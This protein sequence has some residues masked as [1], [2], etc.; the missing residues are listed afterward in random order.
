MWT[1]VQTHYAALAAEENPV[2]VPRAG[3][4]LQ[5][6]WSS[7]I[8][9][10]TSFFMSLLLKV[11]SEEHDGWK[12]ENYIEE[13]LTRFETIRKAEEAETIRAYD[14]AKQQALLRKAD[15]P[16]KP[17]IK[18]TKFR[19][20]H[21]VSILKT[22][23][24]FMHAVMLEKIPQMEPNPARKRQRRSKHSCDAENAVEATKDC[25]ESSD[26]HGKSLTQHKPPLKHGKDSDASS[27]ASSLASDSS[28][29][30][31]PRGE[32][33]GEQTPVADVQVFAAAAPTPSV[34]SS[35]VRGIGIPRVDDGR[36]SSAE[37]S[38][39]RSQRTQQ[40]ANYRLK[41]LTELRGIV[42][43]MS[44][45]ANQI[46]NGTAGPIRMP[47]GSRL[48]PTLAEEVQQD[49]HFFREQKYRLK[50]ELEALDDIGGQTR[51]GS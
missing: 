8:R 34:A 40:K 31:I 7:F 39:L 11:E 21:C 13:T 36:T 30:N 14:E 48:D 16:S 10:E 41:L 17:R 33:N 37:A 49:L 43:T 15:L 29:S 28:S 12:E 20:V 38:M 50:Q 32:S 6:H 25:D 4:A 2:A 1:R 51:V 26:R 42:E 23:K 44:H 9:P 18:V 5:T 46:A 24:R 47:A 45:L 35:D 27:G 19:Y 3:G 22:S